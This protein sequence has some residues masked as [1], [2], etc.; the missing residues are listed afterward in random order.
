M[1]LRKC[2]KL[3]A[4]MI[5]NIAASAAWRSGADVVE[6]LVLI[7]SP[8]AAIRLMA[9][10]TQIITRIAKALALLRRA[11]K[12]WQLFT[13]RALNF[14]D[15]YSWRKPEPARQQLRCRSM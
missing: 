8:R 4:R 13:T 12:R 5:E 7:R 3:S 1:S 6:T 2:E 15:S 11:S 9:A 10:D 14:I